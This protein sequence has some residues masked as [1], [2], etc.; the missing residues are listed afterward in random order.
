MDQ[1]LRLVFENSPFFPTFDHNYV[2]DIAVSDIVDLKIAP[3]PAIAIVTSP[4]MILHSTFLKLNPVLLLKYKM[5][6][7]DLNQLCL[8]YVYP[9]ETIK[10]SAMCATV[11]PEERADFLQSISTPTHHYDSLRLQDRIFEFLTTTINLL[12]LDPSGAHVFDYLTCHPFSTNEFFLN[13]FEI[14]KI[15]HSGISLK[16]AEK[17]PHLTWLSD[18]QDPNLLQ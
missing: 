15:I 2:T 3:A 9:L 4:L 8:G 7:K 18:F 12:N 6:D 11:K 17:L 13:G 10:A 16:V 14:A 5:T 1:N